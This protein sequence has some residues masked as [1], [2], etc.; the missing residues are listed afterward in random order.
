MDQLRKAMVPGRRDQYYVDGVNFWHDRFDRE[1]KRH[2]S[3]RAKLRSGEIA[4]PP[5]LE[6]VPPQESTSV[7]QLHGFML[8]D[9]QILWRSI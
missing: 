2:M 7:A 8:T 6:T 3:L 1:R 4:E 5:A 9:L